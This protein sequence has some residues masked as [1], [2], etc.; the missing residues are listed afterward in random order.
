MFVFG[1]LAGYVAGI[2]TAVC[3]LPQTIKTIR[4][5]NVQ[6]LSFWS[7]LIYDFGLCC[8]I[9]YGFYLHSKQMLIFNTI[10]FILG[11][12]ILYMIIKGKFKK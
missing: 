7:Y 10:A 2:C 4:T 6:S 1:E 12:V 8:W 3:F 9:F 5:K 11:S